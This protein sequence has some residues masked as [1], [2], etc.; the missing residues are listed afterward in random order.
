MQFSPERT[1]LILSVYRA[2]QSNQWDQGWAGLLDR[3]PEVDVAE[4]K[5]N[6]SFGDFLKAHLTNIE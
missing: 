2:E 3:L 1:F 6:S 5:T 4:D